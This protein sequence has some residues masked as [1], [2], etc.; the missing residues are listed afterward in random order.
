MNTTDIMGL[1]TYPIGR[2]KI[3]SVNY[4]MDEAYK[5]ILKAKLFI[6]V[7]QIFDWAFLYRNYR[8]DPN[9]ILSPP[10]L[11]EMRS[12]SW[13]AL[14][15][16]GKGIIFYSLFDIIRMDEISPYEERWKDV[17]EFTNEI[18][19]YKDIILSIDEVNKIE[20]SQ[21]DNVTFKQWKYNNSN[22]I[23]IVNLERNK[24][25]FKIDLLDKFEINKEFGLGTFKENGTEIIFNLEP[26]D[27]IIMQYTEIIKEYMDHSNKSKILIIFFI[28]FIIIIFIVVVFF[29]VKRYFMKKDINKNYIDS[30]SKLMTDDNYLL[31]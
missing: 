15:A 14:V 7:I 21:N 29:F 31:N 2:G 25:R 19:Q 22:Y 3:R 6:S 11:Q 30:V 26:L 1:D 8:G 28:I 13:Q 16:G 10:T 5:E 9:F 24:E 18:W 17:I 4:N 23:V 12:M 27:V 20:Y